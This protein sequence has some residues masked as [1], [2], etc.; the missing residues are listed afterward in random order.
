MTDIKKV[1]IRPGVSILSVL[2]HLNY[3]PWFALAEYVDNAIDSYLKNQNILE[4]LE[5]D[6]QLE[7][8]L[9][10][11]NDRN[12]IVITDNAAGIKEEDFPRAF[13]AAEVPPDNTK[14]SEFGMGMKSASCWFS[15]LWEVRTTSIGDNIERTVTF[16]MNKIYNDSLEELDIIEK[17]VSSNSHYT[18]IT[19]NKVDKKM[20]KGLSMAKVKSHL[21]SIYR[22]Y[23]RDDNLVL[24]LRGE[25]LNYKEPKIM[26]RPFYKDPEGDPIKWKQEIEFDF[27][28]DFSV[29]GF[30]AI[31]DPIENGKS[32]LA[33]FRRGRVIEGS[34]D[35]DDG[36]RPK[37][38]FG[39]SGSFKYKRLFGEL[40]MDG[41]GVS[42]TKDGLQWEDTQ[43]DFI[44]LLIHYLNSGISLPILQQAAYMRTTPKVKDM[45]GNAKGAVN[46]TVKSAI[47]L[48]Q[49]FENEINKIKNLDERPKEPQLPL[50]GKSYKKQFH[51]SLH[52]ENWVVHL[53][54]SY[55]ESIA[56]MIEV[57]EDIVPEKDKV[58]NASNIGVRLSL[59]HPFMVAFA[60]HDKKIIEPILRISVALGL[61]E[62]V[63]K[64]YD[65]GS[66]EV[67][68]TF[69]ELL[70]GSLSKIEDDGFDE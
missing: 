57:G 49:Q 10:F 68:Q 4:R 13:R 33:L 6:Y 18:V 15:D 22:K 35:S 29:K 19:L 14:L 26:N 43:D 11:K 63:A 51:L 20:P 5:E 1:E 21:S 41:F 36:F 23:I 45:E 12:Q 70:S 34:A 9:E 52:D 59:I 38:I 2:K 37:E 30:I 3:K 53:E 39:T 55:D 7:V 60:S 24:K 69:N 48:K 16:D 47:E 8:G 46:N 32:G 27:G 25:P 31:M 40:H 62:F 66:D 28:N 64:Q 44:K 61:S 42:H 58:Q 65:L 56:D 67:Y 17:T 50:E 54:A